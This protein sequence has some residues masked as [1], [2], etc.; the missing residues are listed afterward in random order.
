MRK[1]TVEEGKR[2]GME[3]QKARE[4]EENEIKTQ[5]FITNSMSRFYQESM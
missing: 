5:N 1:M 2:L 4:M 3:H